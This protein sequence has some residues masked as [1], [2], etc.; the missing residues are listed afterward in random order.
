MAQLDTENFQIEYRTECPDPTLVRLWVR[1]ALFLQRP[2]FRLVA[3]TDFTFLACSESSTA[4]QGDS[5][6]FAAK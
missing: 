3:G 2:I 4:S 5:Y 6:C 1:F